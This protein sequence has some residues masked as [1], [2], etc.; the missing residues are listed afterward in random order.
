M[1]LLKK[2]EKVTTF[3]R[4]VRTILHKTKINAYV[5]SGKSYGKYSIAGRFFAK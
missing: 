4:V 2:E 5:H 1:G 3:G